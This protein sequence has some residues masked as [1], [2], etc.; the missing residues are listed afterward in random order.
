MFRKEPT[1]YSHTVYKQ[2]GKVTI[3]QYTVHLTLHSAL[4]SVQRALWSVHLVFYAYLQ[5]RSRISIKGCVRPS[6]GPSVRPSVGPSVTH[7]LNFREMG[8]IPTK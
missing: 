7:E 1:L 5:M 6:V 2:A 4:C 8:R 3:K